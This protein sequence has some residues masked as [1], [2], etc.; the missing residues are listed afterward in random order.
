LK[1]KDIWTIRVRAGNRLLHDVPLS[2][3]AGNAHVDEHRPHI[4]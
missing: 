1:P 3:E 4:G 2:N